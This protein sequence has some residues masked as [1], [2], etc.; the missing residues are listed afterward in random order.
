MTRAHPVGAAVA[1]LLILA[2]AVAM[3]VLAAVNDTLPGDEAIADWVQGWS[4]PG[5]DLSDFVRT[6]TETEVVLA[7]GA[8]VALVFWLRGYRRQAVLLGFG[9]IVMAVMQVV[10]KE[11]V[12][13]PRPDPELVMRR[14]G[15]DSTSFPSGHVMSATVLYGAL[16]YFA[17]T[18]LPGMPRLAVVLA[19][20]F[21]LVMTPVVSVWLGVHWPSDVV[22]SWLWAAVILL[23]IVVLDRSESADEPDFPER[24]LE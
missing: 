16:L 10:L 18:L 2:M 3:T 8:A 11:M 15:F 21:L 22:G 4:V 23:P 5:N 19:C 17:L 14:S 1:W 7:T 13:R 20:V 6:V 12:D 24:S 9:L